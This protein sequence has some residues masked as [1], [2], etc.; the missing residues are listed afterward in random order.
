M[1]VAQGGGAAG[2]PPG[3]QRTALAPD[4]RGAA[5]QSC[6]GRLQLPASTSLAAPR[7]EG[8]C[9][10]RTGELDLYGVAGPQCQERHS[11]PAFARRVT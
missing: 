4:G 6:S 2:Q 1:A 7:S 9:A 5:A 8:T 3:P 10:Y 11:F